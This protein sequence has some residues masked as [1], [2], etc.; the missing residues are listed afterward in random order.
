R[1]VAA[2]NACNQS[3][4]ARLA[5]KAANTGEVDPDALRNMRQAHEPFLALLKERV[6]VMELLRGRW[7]ARNPNQAIEFAANTSEPAVLVDL[8]SIL[9][10]MEI[11]SWKLDTA[12]AVLPL[13]NNLMASK[14]SSHVETACDTLKIVLKHF[15]QLISSTAR[16]LP[17]IGVDLCQE[18]R[19]NKCQDC[20]YHLDQLRDS[21]SS[22]SVIEKAGPI[23]R[24]A[25]IMFELLNS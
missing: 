12:T 5:S 21:L 4:A 8:L 7:S 1:S 10:R 23:G 9:N 25:R 14:Y 2:G 17:S 15:G 13:L 6:R 20:M 22:D 11:K 19:V 3:E 18:S 16:G 24:E